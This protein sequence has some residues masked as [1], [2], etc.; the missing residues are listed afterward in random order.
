MRTEFFFEPTQQKK[1][2]S[3]LIESFRLTFVLDCNFFFVCVREL[4]GSLLPSEPAWFWLPVSLVVFV[5]MRGGA[6]VGGCVR[7]CACLC[8]GGGRGGG[9][10]VTDGCGGVGG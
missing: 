4:L 10:R 6:C 7:A 5:C 2:L 8:V 3:E 9:G 1:L